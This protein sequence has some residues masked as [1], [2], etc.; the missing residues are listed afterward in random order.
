M[1]VTI[2]CLWCCNVCLIYA[3]AWNADCEYVNLTM[4]CTHGGF[5]LSRSLAIV[6]KATRI[7]FSSA[8]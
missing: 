7:A 1:S 5:G 8:P 2:G 6:R 3:M 4:L